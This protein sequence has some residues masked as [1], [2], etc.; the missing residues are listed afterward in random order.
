[1]KNLTWPAV[2]GATRYEFRMQW[3]RRAVWVTLTLFSLLAFTGLSNPW[4]YPPETP[5]RE[6]VARWALVVQSFMPIAVGVLLADRLP[7]DR[8]THVDELLRALPAPSGGRLLGKYL[9][10]TLGTLP[11]L[12]L[13]YAAGLGYLA[14]DRGASQ[15]M[16]LIALGL[17]AFAAINL[18]GLLFV[19]AFSVACPAVLWVPLYQFLFVGYWFWGN[20][21]GP[22]ALPIP[23]L[24]G[25][26]LTPIGQYPIAGFFGV[27]GLWV[28]EA[29]A[30]EGA[31]SI[32][33]LLVLAA[34]ALLAAHWYL[35]REAARG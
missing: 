23:T 4:D 27:E 30:W 33:L 13:V 22:D 17:A 35:R 6:V 18:P 25:T 2:A 10:G 5:L 9:G 3:R 20:L 31:A 8:R 15:L 26:W 16:P 11:P 21:L 28:S 29:A 32:G 12:L 7:R 34:L 1:M 19:G 24:S 14:V